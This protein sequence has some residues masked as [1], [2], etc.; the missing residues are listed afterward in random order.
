MPFA[1]RPPRTAA[2]ASESDGRV[3]L[4]ARSGS[5]RHREIAAHVAPTCSPTTSKVA[6]IEIYFPPVHAQV[7]V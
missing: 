2:R 3:L 7:A 5:G 6:D 4:L 1:A